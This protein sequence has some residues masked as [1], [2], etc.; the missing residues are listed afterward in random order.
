MKNDY[1]LENS[2]NIN[3]D[4]VKNIVLKFQ[5]KDKKFDFHK[6]VAE[7]ADIPRE[8]AKVINLGLLFSNNRSS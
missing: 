6:V 1:P 4:I 7:M 5:E 2:E 8:Q 3:D